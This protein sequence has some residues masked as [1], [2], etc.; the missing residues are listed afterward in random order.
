MGNSI[1]INSTNQ[2]NKKVLSD[3]C[4]VNDT[5]ALIGKRWLMTVLYEISSGNNQFTFLRKSI[6]EIS[7]HILGTR[8]NDL[9]QQKLITKK[10]I[11]NTVPLQIMYVVT[12][13][14]EEL[15]SLVNEL[16][17]WDRNWAR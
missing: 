13:K 3:R 5:L 4:G 8:I 15:L 16:C 12:V 1:K 7:E 10:E 17:I 6:P 11:E 9:V 2:A 14:G